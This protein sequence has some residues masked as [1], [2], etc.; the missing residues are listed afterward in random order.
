MVLR[1][2]MLAACVFCAVPA[3]FSAYIYA[4]SGTGGAAWWL[5]AIGTA[6]GVVEGT[7]L[8]TLILRFGVLATSAACLLAN[9]LAHFPLTIDPSM[10]YFGTSLLCFVAVAIPL[11]FAFHSALAGRPVFRDALLRASG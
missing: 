5:A 11:F 4:A 8:I 7:L 10:P 2:H 1:R 3:A 6:S 9:L